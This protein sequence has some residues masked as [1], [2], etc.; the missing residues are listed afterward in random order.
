MEI[1]PHRGQETI[2]YLLEGELDH[3]DFAGHRGTLYPGDLQFMTAGRGIM[4]AEIPRAGILNIALQLW[5][6]LPTHLKACEPRYRNLRASEIPSVRIDNGR[7]QIKVIS[8]NSHGVNS[9]RDLAYTPVWILDFSI[10]PGGKATQPLPPGWN[11]FLYVLEGEVFVGKGSNMRKVGQCE[12]VLFAPE[13]EV[14]FIQGDS[15]DGKSFRAILVAGTPHDQPIVQRGPF[16]LT[17]EEEARQAI[18]DYSTSTNGFELARHW[19]SKI[20]G[21]RLD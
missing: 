10:M 8:G 2:T 19:R 12:I 6:D 3:E 7:V 5:V 11:A 9:V 21:Q 14:V 4:H 20:G 17:S 1:S 16:V 18:S 15:E 13:G